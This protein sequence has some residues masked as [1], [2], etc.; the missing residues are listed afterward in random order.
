MTYEYED[1]QLDL[2][3][4]QNEKIAA[5]NEAIST[6]EGYQAM[7]DAEEAASNSRSID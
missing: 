2:T 7:L 3:A 1:M 4:L 5:M 6:K